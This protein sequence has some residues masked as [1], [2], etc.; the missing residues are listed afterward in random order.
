VWCDM[1]CEPREVTRK[2]PRGEGGKN[3]GMELLEGYGCG[4]RSHQLMQ[5]ECL[6]C[7]RKYCAS[8]ASECRS[9]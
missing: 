4:W 7:Y 3:S 1:A 5:A 6:C 2:D 8:R 9:G